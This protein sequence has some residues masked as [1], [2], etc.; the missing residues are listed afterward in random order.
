MLVF[1]TKINQQHQKF[2]N[3]YLYVDKIIIRILDTV[4]IFLNHIILS[5]L[6][7]KSNTY[8]ILYLV[9]ISQSNSVI[10]HSRILNHKFAVHSSIFFNELGVTPQPI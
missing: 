9:T 2:R 10:F 5:Q 8:E 1:Y 6:L 4:L 3:V 7:I